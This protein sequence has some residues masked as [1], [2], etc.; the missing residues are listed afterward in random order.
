MTIMSIYTSDN[1]Y[2]EQHGV[3]RV[4]IGANSRSMYTYKLP[5]MDT[6]VNTQTAVYIFSHANQCA[7]HTVRP[8]ATRPMVVLLKLAS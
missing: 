2:A 6:S 7:K 4:E 5:Y 1:Q 8:A 3:R